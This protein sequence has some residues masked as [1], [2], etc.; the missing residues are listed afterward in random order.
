MIFSLLCL[1][2]YDINVKP[3][4]NPDIASSAVAQS[5]KIPIK[6]NSVQSIQFSLGENS[7]GRMFYGQ[8]LEGNELIYKEDY[9][10][11]DTFFLE[12]CAE[13]EDF[14]PKGVYRFKLNSN[15]NKNDIIT[16]RLLFNENY[17]IKQT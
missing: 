14:I 13:D 3:V 8:L 7:T 5:I 16:I 1:A 4:I 9:H 12:F 10:R 17:T 2:A 6:G 15:F 11:T